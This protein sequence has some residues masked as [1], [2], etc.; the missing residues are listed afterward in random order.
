MDVQAWLEGLGLG[1]YTEAFAANHIDGPTLR[2]L[3]SDDLRELGVASLGHRK[4][5]LEAIASLADDRSVGRS[6]AERRQ[7]AVLFA[8]L[9][10][11]T[12]L[13]AELGAE[14]IRR[15]VD[16]F[17]ARAD[18]I[19]VE[20]GGSV[21]KHIGDATMALFGAPVAHED[22]PLRAV[23]AA[24][25]LQRA[26]AV[27]SAELG[28]PATAPLATHIGIALGE[29]VAGEVGGNVRRDYTVLGDTVNL[30]ARLVGEAGRGETVLDAAA[31]RAVSGRVL[32]TSLG[33][34]VLKGI[35]RPQHLWRLEG[36]REAA[37]VG[38]LPFVGRE[39]ELAQISAVLAAA[40]PGAVLL[41]RGEAGI[42][43]SRLLVETM[44][45]A[46]RRGFM[47][48]LIRVLD[49][50][51]ARRQAPLRM[52]AEA[53]AVHRPGWIDDPSVEPGLRAA[54]HDVLDRAM[55]ADL[56]VPY[57]AMEDAK[58]AVLRAEAVAAFGAAVA[59]EAPLVIAV[60]DLHWANDTLR[61]LVRALARLTVSTRIVLLMTSRPEGDSVDAAFR[62]DLAGAS[63]AV[64][65]LGP[66]HPDATYRLAQA[67]A[68]AVDRVVIER[69]VARSGGNP[70]FLEQLALSAVEAEAA[71]LPTSIRG[72]VQARLDRLERA[73][74]AA[75][76]AA[77]VLGQRFSLAALQTLAG[78]RTYDPR[79]LIDG[80]LLVRDADMLMFA[81]ALIQE[82]TYA[83]LLGETARRLHRRAADWLGDG[84]PELRAQHLER[85]GDPA[86]ASAYRVAAVRLRESARLAPAL[87]CAE[88][89]LALAREEADFVPLALL[90]GHLRIDLGAPREARAHFDAASARASDESG[91]GE[92][93]FG[94]AAA[95]RIVD[96][97]AGAQQA[98]DRAQA[99]AEQGDLQALGSRCRHL[100]GNLMFPRG[101]VDECMEEHR[102]ALVLAERAQSPELVARA[103]GG[104]AD[105]FYAQGRMRSALDALERCIAAAHSA[106]AAAVEIAN[107][108]MAA[109]AECYM[110]RLDAMRESAA[111]ARALA[112]QAQNRR[113][114]LV[115]LHG[116]I[117]AAME[118]NS[119]EDGLPHVAEARRIVAELGAWRF[120]GENVTFGA[121][122]EAAAGRTA[123]AVELAREAVDLCRKHA[124]SYMG[125]V[126][127]GIG[128]RLT[129]DAA[130]RDGWLAEGEALLAGPTLGHNH[131]FFRRNAIEA[132]LNARR[133]DRARHHA[134]ALAAYA[135]REPMPF[136]DLVSRRG[137]LLADAADGRLTPQTRA[138]LHELARRAERAGYHRLATP[139]L[140]AL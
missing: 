43:K 54:L 11:F 108:P 92:A 99:I 15:V 96:D 36:L 47:P 83:S 82:A 74:R 129:D 72:L 135:A 51:A 114:E 20:H 94:V 134:T 63:I 73:D 106:G 118:S 70:L 45:E 107:R 53:L 18:E 21:D 119:P 88:R 137:V 97:L 3:T 32:A 48:I 2:S 81:H 125:A 27:L 95:L 5:L 26:M 69:F 124:M 35:A 40:Q 30:A 71:S 42:G 79:P 110:L 131:L 84:E 41:L 59:A 109:I 128:A 132:E 19:M 31:W 98:L 113:A 133:P 86:A 50:G 85:A 75:L 49:F 130:E 55:P 103:L 44:A 111:T 52:L 104:L 76:Q 7:V 39:V 62:R 61:A 65:E 105:A 37:T 68:S 80:G 60:E 16:R 29:V 90:A 77:S 58:R 127:L 8:D 46:E 91:R 126:A 100:R 121:D 6:E 22:D 123:R 93:Q 136:T 56:A 1:Q 122:L 102:A 14:E 140:E 117:I 138:E 57:A 67:A 66:L 101:L 78:D 87:E 139:M 25:A 34:R 64:V 33:D 13:S 17:L 12:E 115:S 23:A 89:G 116:L 10:G 28:R 120:E 24:D 38:R 9:C 4:R 112:R